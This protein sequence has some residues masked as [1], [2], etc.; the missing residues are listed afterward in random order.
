MFFTAHAIWIIERTV[1]GKTTKHSNLDKE[2]F[3]R[4]YL[5]GL[6]DGV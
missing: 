2:G 1:Y 6:K 3:N 5:D 4:Y